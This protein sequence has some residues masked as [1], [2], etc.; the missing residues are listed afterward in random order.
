MERPYQY[1]PAR[2]FLIAYVATWI[3]WFVGIYLGTQPGLE[4]YAPLLSLV[5]LLGPIGATLFMVLSSGSAH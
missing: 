5:G 4:A 1:R 3:P 2:F